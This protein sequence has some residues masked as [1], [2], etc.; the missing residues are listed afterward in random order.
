MRTEIMKTGGG[1]VGKDLEED[2]RV[3]NPFTEKMERDKG[4]GSKTYFRG[5]L[6]GPTNA[7]M[8]Q[9]HI[10]RTSDG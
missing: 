5:T 4:E 6:G 3:V 9:R 2:S 1:D 10:R 7:K 8:G